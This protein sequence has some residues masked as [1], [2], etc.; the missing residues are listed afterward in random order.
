MLITAPVL[1]LV[2]VCA[3]AGQSFTPL[4]VETALFQS[5]SLMGNASPCSL[6]SDFVMCS[7]YDTKCGTFHLNLTI[8][9]Q[10]VLML[11]M[12][13]CWFG[14]ANSNASRYELNHG[15]TEAER[16]RS[17]LQSPWLRSGSKSVFIR[18]LRGRAR[19][20]ARGRLQITDWHA[21]TLSQ[22]NGKF[23]YD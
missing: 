1:G 11:S 22:R 8:A 6:N 13:N 23:S 14:Y 12:R 7:S 10:S 19:G 20:R 9:N 15:G 4:V 5:S 16:R 21:L 17:D 2:V 3:P 18:R